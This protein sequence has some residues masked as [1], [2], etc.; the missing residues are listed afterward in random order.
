MGAAQANSFGSAERPFAEF[1]AL[2]SL[3]KAAVAA[4]AD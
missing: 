4:M 3:A 1:S 2:R